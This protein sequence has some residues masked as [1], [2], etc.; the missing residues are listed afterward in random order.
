[1]PNKIKEIAKEKNIKIVKLSEETGLARSY[2]YDLIN[3]K[4]S[5][6]LRTARLIAT[7]LNST[8]DEIFPNDSNE[9]V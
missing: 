9:I 3:Q 5:P 4:S 2:L 7:V 1:M 6:N 8:I